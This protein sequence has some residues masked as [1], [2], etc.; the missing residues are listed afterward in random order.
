MARGNNMEILLGILSLLSFVVGIFVLFLFSPTAVQEIEGLLLLILSGILL[1][2]AAVVSAVKGLGKTAESDFKKTSV[3]VLSVAVIL[4]IPLAALGV[5]F[6][7]KALIK[8]Q[9]MSTGAVQEIVQFEAPIEQIGILEVPGV[10]TVYVVY[11][12]RD[13]AR[14]TNAMYSENPAYLAEL[15]RENA[16]FFVPNN[17]QVRVIDMGQLK[18]EIRVLDGPYAD[19]SGWVKKEFVRLE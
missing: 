8:S 1:S 18:A 2:G 6:G 19:R 13:V 9:A 10:E 4:L 7:T 17:T 3:K 15:T 16:V 11:S 12:M 5:Y 14:A